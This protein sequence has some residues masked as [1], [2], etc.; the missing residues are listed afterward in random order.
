MEMCAVRVP[1][2]A[3]TLNWETRAGAAETIMHPRVVWYRAGHRFPYPR[4]RAQL[5]LEELEGREVLSGGSVSLFDGN[6]VV[7]GMS[8]SEP[9]TVVVNGSNYRFIDPNGLT[10]G[11]GTTQTNA[12]TVDVPIASVTGSLQIDAI[13]GN[14]TLTV[15]TSGGNFINPIT[16]DGGTGTDDGL[17]VKGT[18]T[19]TATYTP[20]GTNTGDGTVTTSAG[21]VS[22]V[23]LKPLDVTGFGTAT[24]TFPNANDVVSVADGFDYLS[25]GTNRALNVTG[26]SG[27]VAFEKAAFWNDT[28]VVIDTTAV[29]GTDAVTVASA[30]NANGITNFTVNEPTNQAGTIAITGPVSFPGSVSLT[31]G[32]SITVNA[33]ITG[34]SGGT[35]LFAGGSSSHGPIGVIVEN[36][37]VVTATG[38]GPVTVTGTGGS[39]GGDNYGVYVD[40]SGSTITSGGGGTVTVTGTGGSTSVYHNYGVYVEDST[41]TSGGGNV[42]V[43]G[44]GG[45]SSGSDGNNY[46]VF[47]D[48]SDSTITSGGGGT[49]TV[50]GTGGSG[51]TGVNIGVFVSGSTITSGGGGSVT[52]TGTGGSG[53]FG[54]NFGVWV[55]ASGQVTSGGGG[56]VTVTGTGGSGPGGSNYGVLVSSSSKV[57][58]GGGAVNV[59]GTGTATSEAVY[60]DYDGA[61]AS[62]SNAPI[63]ITADSLFL[64]T[65]STINSRTGLTTIVPLTAGTLIALGGNEVLTGS[66]L[67]LGLSAAEIA[68]ITAGT[69]NIGNTSS[70]AVAVSAAITFS[71]PVVNVTTGSGNAI[72]FTG[73]GS[74]KSSGFK[75][76]LT[77]SGTGAITSTT[78]ATD[79]AAG[80]GTISLNGGSGGIGVSGSPI[81]VSGT[82]LDATTSGN[83]NEYL[84]AVG[85][86]T[87]DPTGL[88]AGTGTVEL[89]G[90]TFTLG[91]NNRI[92]ASAN[93]NVN[94]ATFAVGAFDQTVETLILTIG[95][96][97]GGTGVLTSTNTIQAQSGSASAILAGT[98][99]LTKF[100][101]GTVT[102]SAVN[103]Y[104]G[105]TTVFA[106]TLA[107]NGSITSSVTN[108]GTLQGSGTITGNVSGSG[109]FSPGNN[110]TPGIMTINGNFTPSGT[111]TFKVNTPYATV[112]TDYDQYSVSGIV[113]LSG[114][115]LTL[116]NN[117]PGTFPPQPAL[118][119]LINH[120][121]G[122]GLTIPGSPA[123]GSSLSLGTNTV[124]LFYNGNH[125]N[126]VVIVNSITPTTSTTLVAS[127]NPAQLLQPVVFTATVTPEAG[128]GPIPATDT[129]T[130]TIDGGTAQQ[131]VITVY[132]VPVGGTSSAATATLNT[133]ALS[134]GFLAAGTHTVTAVFNGDTSNFQASPVVTLSP[135]ETVVAPVLGAASGTATNIASFGAAGYISPVTSPGVQD[136]FVI[137]DTVTQ[138]LSVTPTAPTA[139]I[140][141]YS[142]SGLTTLVRSFAATGGPLS[143]TSYPISATWNGKNIS[144]TVVPD[145]TYYV[146]VTFTDQ[147]ENTLTSTPITVVV[148]DTPPAAPPVASS[149]AVVSPT[150]AGGIPTTTQ[151][152]DTLT[153]A[154][155][156]SWTINIYSGSTAPANLVRTFTGATDNVLA[157]WNGTDSTNTNLPTGHYTIQLIADDLAGNQTISGT[158]SVYVFTKPIVTVTAS[159][160]VVYGQ[161]V[162]LTVDIT[163]I[164]TLTPT[165]TV[166]VTYGTTDMGSRSLVGGM[167]TVPVTQLPAGTFTLTVTYS[168]DTNYSGS[169]GTVVVTVNPAPLQVVANSVTFVYGG[170][171]TLPALTFGPPVGL[172]Y[173]DTAKTVLTGTLTTAATPTS[174][175]GS[176]SID[177]GT[178]TA[179]SNYILT[180]IPATLSI[181]AAAL[182]VTANNESFV[183]GGTLPQL[184]YQ[185]PVGLVNG[186]SA[187]VLSGQLSTTA[188]STSGVGDYPITQGTLSAGNNYT[189]TVVPATLFIT[190][191]PLT[192]TANSL[193]SVYGGLF[194]A[195]LT[196]TTQGLENGDTA[197]SVLTGQ[198]T[199]TASPNS[200]VGNYPIA[201]GTLAATTNYTLTVIPATLTIT[202]AP[203]TVT[204]KAVT[205]VYSQ[206]LP[207]LTYVGQGLVNG[208]LPSSVFT[209]ALATTAT[210]SSPVGTYPI[211]QGSLAANGDYTLHFVGGYLT[212]T[213]APLTIIINDAN[214]RVN[215]PNQPFTTTFQGLVNGDTQSVVT[216]YTLTST[217]GTASPVGTY[218]I[219]V[220]GT[221]T[222]QDYTITTV[223]GT[224]TVNIARET[225]TVSVNPVNITYGTA[226]AN[227]QLSGTATWTIGADPVTVAG[228]F[229]YT[230]AAGTVLHAANGQS[231]AVTFTPN[232]ITDYTTVSLS[233]TVNVARAT[234]IVSVNPVN[235]ISGTALANSHLSGTATWTIGGNPVTVAG[236]FT[237]TSAAGTVLHAANGQS[238]AITFTPN[239][240]TDYN[241]AAATVIVRTMLIF[242]PYDGPITPTGGTALTN[243]LVTNVIPGSGNPILILNGGAGATGTG[244]GPG[245]K[246]R[247]NSIPIA[248]L[249]EGEAGS[250][251]GLL[252]QES[253]FPQPETPL[254]TP[255]IVGEEPPLRTVL[256]LDPTL[257]VASFSESGGDNMAFVDGLLR[258]PTVPNR[259]PPIPV[260]T[261]AI[262]DE[263]TGPGQDDGALARTAIWLGPIVAVG[264]A[265]VAGVRPAR[266]LARRVT[267]GTV[268]LSFPP[269]LQREPSMNSPPPPSPGVGETG[270][271]ISET[272]KVGASATEVSGSFGAAPVNP[273]TAATITVVGT[274]AAAIPPEVGPAGTRFGRY[275]LL[276]EIARGGMGVVYR[277]RQE[278][279]ERV[280]A[281]KMILGTGVDLDTT[282]RFLQEAQA[283][284]AIDHPN[285][286]P[287]YDSGEADARPYFTMALVNGPNLRDYVK[288]RGLLP[289]EEAAGLFAQIVAGVAHAHQHG[290]IHR[291]LKPANVLID[292]NGRPRVTDFG[293]AKRLAGDANLTATGQVIGTPA[294]MAPE[295]ARD[296]KDVGPPADVYALGA[297]LYFLLTGRPPF[298]GEGMTDLLIKVVTE[299][300]I[301]PRTFNPD[302]PPSIEGICL[303]CLSKSPADRPAN[304]IALAAAFAVAA[305][306]YLAKS[307]GTS[308]LAESRLPDGL[309]V[310]EPSHAAISTVRNVPIT[311]ERPQTIRDPVQ[312]TAP[313][314]GR[315]SSRPSRRRLIIGLAVAAV[316][317]VGVLIA[318]AIRD[319]RVNIPPIQ[320]GFEL[321]A[322]LTVKSVKRGPNGLLLLSPGTEIQIHLRAERDCRVRVWAINPDG[323][324]T[325]LL[326]NDYELDD[327]L[328]A[329]VTRVIPGNQKYT[330]DP[331][332]TVGA[333]ND[334][335]FVYATTGTPLAS[336]PGKNEGPFE[337]VRGPVAKEFQQGLRGIGIKPTG[338]G[339]KPTSEG[340]AVSELE[341]RV[342]E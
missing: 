63:T 86:I 59:T 202:P 260:P 265:V 60:L 196:Y 226:L 102:L 324:M 104:T 320:A 46:G 58:S 85:S 127:V 56:T 155:L 252:S 101:T 103:S 190:P 340:V 153:E 126:D 271:K 168:G 14:D 173:S 55:L 115:T 228:T 212:V 241:A 229:T 112:G 217:A 122:G 131:Q 295:Q 98:N 184:T 334:R 174:G 280:V 105:P 36:G 263:S 255:P 237:Y 125:H 119:T 218:P 167:A 332:L 69:L 57:T 258:D 233:V 299:D 293:L 254:P 251:L 279:L 195:T 282:R 24:M 72:T 123:D 39:G 116:T 291:D 177:Q 341:F 337:V 272:G 90:G 219:I 289:V 42:L 106:G 183:Y 239:D 205:K 301:L 314:T 142:N 204:V 51:S 32:Q 172:Q 176:Y 225:P 318:L 100:S 329:G 290:I 227:S 288:N 1:G 99:G 327:K 35:T 244:P 22:F 232:D 74:L 165:G 110:P 342:Q 154:N 310:A 330:L 198:L 156:S 175:A 82:N 77:T 192:V 333:G 247:F 133:S 307:G 26:T 297:I 308:G 306:P 48:G 149:N 12:T 152:T 83:G 118:L 197:A 64:D 193:T 230:T 65:T 28:K 95:S 136:T 235:L 88:N 259:G 304:A 135:N 224:L 124:K 287:V 313:D 266:R 160:P 261:P 137:T 91:G 109:T 132:V 117:L 321:K 316:V 221:P 17:V 231:E 76:T 67:T 66:P 203:L 159:S 267:V 20:D 179:S 10:A 249:L 182:T 164:G 47:V 144:G 151:L 303:R 305:G 311:N 111:V 45:S 248:S 163:G 138:V 79:I 129:V 201:A 194:P 323:K 54:N 19:Q 31:A 68:Q 37:A 139:T 296:S 78:G 41:I 23:N 284:A 94:R 93:L 30:N 277:A 81:I 49:V 38:N 268:P 73:T 166:D 302:V 207:A 245:D 71:S 274:S 121:V 312:A 147:Y 50:T 29:P 52:V 273:E 140:N 328:T 191:A 257:P 292:Q 34:G 338:E 150:G 210:A 7:T 300:P 188:T 326:P 298:E 216:G 187:S 336:P 148:D 339:I 189:L 223:P 61:I 162:P 3:I 199:T 185:P 253:L 44:Q 141:V 87:I 270:T 130:F 211:T 43:T 286:V 264:L 278:G 25:G 18:S 53:P 13:I 108:S 70:G 322:Y 15:D 250:N 236:T 220:S 96:I 180:V 246:G 143:G 89:D 170:V 234:P 276:G 215:T 283:A 33:N 114:S 113:N 262:P 181:T 158:S 186:D 169:S 200:R 294:Y 315:T 6:V 27:G 325:R 5:I 146:T 240:I 145:G 8:G 214:K 84:T 281:L 80:T 75:V 107:V 269:N 319:V 209:G 208:D 178:L 157:V 161:S 11:T 222:A 128:A 62:G 242:G 213:P 21:T 285:V 134:G 4:V 206:I 309:V 256:P 317:L 16:Y 120:A 243:G 335:F 171:A 9:I 331:E 40:G 97:T 2:P 92:N 275:E 238:E